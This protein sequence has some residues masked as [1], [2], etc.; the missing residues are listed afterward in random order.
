MLNGRF[1]DKNNFTSVSKKRIAIVNQDNN[2]RINSLRQICTIRRAIS[3]PN[4]DYLHKCDRVTVER[5]H[6]MYTLTGLVGVCDPEHN[7][8]DHSLLT[9]SYN[10]GDNNESN[11]CASQSVTSVKAKRYDVS[12]IPLDFM[13][14]NTSAT[15]CNTIIENCAGNKVDKV[16][17]DFMSLVKHNMFKTLPVKRVATNNGNITHRNKSK[18]SRCEYEKQYCSSSYETGT[19]HRQLFINEQK[20]IDNAVNVLKCFTGM[21]NSKSYCKSIK[22]VIFGKKSEKL[23]LVITVITVS[24]GKLS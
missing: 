20:K 9:W 19:V 7:I 17:D 3:L 10:H 24:H 12:N 11:N 2:N 1:T 22:V 18:Y 13:C 4:Q 5:A 15:R 6:D 21:N 8:P 23:E 14:N 16:Y